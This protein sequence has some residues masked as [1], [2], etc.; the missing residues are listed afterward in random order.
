MNQKSYISIHFRSISGF[1]PFWHACAEKQR[2]CYI[3]V[4]I[5][6][7]YLMFDYYLTVKWFLSN[8]AYEN[9]IIRSY[10]SFFTTK[11]SH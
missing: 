11:N 7:Y 5:T 10:W 3:E 9:K 2:N 6:D 8:I 1:R 4:A